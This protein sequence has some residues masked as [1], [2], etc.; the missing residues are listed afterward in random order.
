[1]NKKIG[2]IRFKDLKVPVYYSTV[3]S[4]GIFDISWRV[5]NPDAFYKGIIFRNNETGEITYP[6]GV[7][8]PPEP[9]EE[10]KEMIPEFIISP[11]ENLTAT[12]KYKLVKRLK[13]QY[14]IKNNKP[15]END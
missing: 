13:Y 14:K 8:P 5:K 6:N 9:T 10:D 2:H 15:K 4:Q 1:M 11:Y 7:E 3:S 12:T